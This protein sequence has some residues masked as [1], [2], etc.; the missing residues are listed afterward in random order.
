[1]DVLV[2][3]SLSSWFSSSSTSLGSLSSGQYLLVPYHTEAFTQ[4]HTNE[5]QAEVLTA[6]N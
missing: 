3:E 5:T 6:F 1:M 2:S 4:K